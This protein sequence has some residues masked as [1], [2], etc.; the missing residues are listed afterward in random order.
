MDGTLVD[1]LPFLK[2]IF[3]DLISNSEHDFEYFNGKFIEKILEETNKKDLSKRYKEALVN[4]YRTDVKLFPGAL[5][6]I[7]YLKSKNKNL[8]LVTSA[9]EEIAKLCLKTLEI[10]DYFFKIFPSDNKISKPSPEVYLKAL[11]ILKIN[12]KEAISIEDS[13]NGVKSS[14]GAGIMTYCIFNHGKNTLLLKHMTDWLEM[15]NEF[16]KIFP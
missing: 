2:T 13:L 3:F 8:V 11:N 7:Q 14:T 9:N 6:C 12:Q 4:Y 1:S 15:L 5:E 16:K 10:A